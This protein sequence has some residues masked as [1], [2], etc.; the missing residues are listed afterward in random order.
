M[1]TFRTDTLLIKCHGTHAS[2][3]DLLEYSNELAAYIN[4][5]CVLQVCAQH[6]HLAQNAPELFLYLD[7]AQPRELEA[8]EFKQVRQAVS[9]VATPARFAPAVDRLEQAF[10]APGASAGQHAPFHYTVE[11]NPSP[12]WADEIVTWYN[13]EHSPGLAAVSGCVCARR[14]V[15]HDSGPQSLACYDLLSPEI[16]GSEAWLAVRQ[17]S[18]S[19]RVR[20][21]FLNTRRTMFRTLGAH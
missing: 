21:K 13:N 6:A 16:L 2:D 18:W 19:D 5:H 15:N 1:A 8:A 17:T 14:F 20:P 12:G 7:L 11:M 3:A 4:E 9:E 10:H